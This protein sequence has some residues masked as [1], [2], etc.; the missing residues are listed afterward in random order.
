MTKLELPKSS[1][2][3]RKAMQPSK[4]R[5]A[6]FAK[7][8]LGQNFLVDKSAIEKIITAVGH[9]LP[10]LLEIGPGRGALSTSLFPLA[11]KFCLLEK[12]DLFAKEIGETLFVHGS[13]KHS[14]FH[15]D[16]LDFDWNRLWT[17]SES[18]PTTP[19]TVVANLPY[20]V[21]TEI[22]FRLI[23]Q[24]YRIPRMILMFQKEVGQRIA[25]PHGNRS[26]GVISVMVQNY[27]DVKIQQILKPGAF[28]PS[29]KVDS[30]V[31]EFTLRPTPLVPLKETEKRAFRSLV[32]SGFA[33][34][35]K[36]IENSLLLEKIRLALPPEEAKARIQ[37]GLL[38]AKIDPKDRAERLSVS[39]WGNLFA[40]LYEQK[41]D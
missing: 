3:L 37:R 23:D 19:L 15:E 24:S 9:S 26:F 6:P 41:V 22:L 29:P 2:Y 18:N 8:S 33:H 38:G 4:N 39:D 10:L 31:L 28:R 11:D 5:K 34:R 35:R 12:D 40:A 14:I 1:W 30:A 17:E 20:N 13:R 36:T 25:A 16:A 7:K 27:Y 21:A 32:Q